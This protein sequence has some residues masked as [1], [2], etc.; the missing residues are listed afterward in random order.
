MNKPV[1]PSTYVH[2]LNVGLIR[3]LSDFI[4]L[5]EG[6]K[7]LAVAIKKPSG[8]DR[9][10]QF[11]LRRC[12]GLLQTGKSA[13]GE[14]LFHQ[15]TTNCT[16]GDPVNLLVQNEFFAPASLLLP[17]AIPKTVNTLPHRE[18]VT[19]EQNQRP[20]CGKDRKDIHDTCVESSIKLY[21]T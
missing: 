18:A 15:G 6:W 12:E 1:T 9:Y 2:C 11:H 8:D 10:N 20:L 14:L 13:T 16:V 5:R 3:E 21:A 4:D 17:D 7:K 19:V